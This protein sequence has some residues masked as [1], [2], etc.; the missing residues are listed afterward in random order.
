[1]A[2][3]EVFGLNRRPRVPLA[4]VAEPSPLTRHVAELRLWVELHLHWRKNLRFTGGLAVLGQRSR[5]ERLKNRR[6][7]AL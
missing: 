4:S 5:W 6:E 7:K 2:S 3:P 1:M